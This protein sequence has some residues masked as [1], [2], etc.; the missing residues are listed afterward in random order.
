VAAD[1][2]ELFFVGR[3]LRRGETLASQ[4][5]GNEKCRVVVRL[6]LRGECAPPRE[7]LL[8][9]GQQRELMAWN[10]RRQQER[11][12]RAALHGR[13]GGKGG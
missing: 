8:D 2:A 1:E 4:L 12:V 7:P 6:A 10:Y 3:Q 11:Q 5:G 9:E 13:A